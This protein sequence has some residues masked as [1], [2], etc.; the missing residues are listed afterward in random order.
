MIETVTP[1]LREWVREVTEDP[2]SAG[3]R[4]LERRKA[5]YLRFGKGARPPVVLVPDVLRALRIKDGDD[6]LKPENVSQSVHE[7]L[8]PVVEQAMEVFRRHRPDLDPES[9][10]NW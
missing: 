1:E 7:Q 3:V 9:P 6:D 4:V 10:Q 5:D 2:R 8:A